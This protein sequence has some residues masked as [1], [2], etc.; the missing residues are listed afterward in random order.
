MRKQ[1]HWALHGLMGTVF[2][3][4]AFATIALTAS[5]QRRNSKMAYRSIHATATARS[6]AGVAGFKTWRAVLL[7]AAAW[8][9]GSGAVLARGHHGS[10]HSSVHFYSP[11]V[12][13]SV[14]AGAPVVVYPNPVLVQQAAPIGPRPYPVQVYSRPGVHVQPVHVQPVYVQPVY[15]QPVVV[16]PY[17]GLNSGYGQPWVDRHSHRHGHNHW[18]GRSGG[19]GGHH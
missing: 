11:G 4:F 3:P 6:P 14:S 5:N 16:S 12:S 1:R 2:M 7:A 10:V 17:P 19:R 8:G 13:V 18:H 9:L 15:V